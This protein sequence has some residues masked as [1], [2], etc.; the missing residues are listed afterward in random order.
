M[1]AATFYETLKKFGITFFSG[2]P[3]SLLKDF[4]AYVTR[5][6]PEQHISAANEGAAVG[7]A[8]GH[9]L[10]TGSIP[11]VYMQNSGLGNAINPL[12][13]LA[14]TDVYRIPML[15]IIGWR[16][17]PG[18]KD[19]PQHQVQ[20][21]ITL[22]ILK[23]LGI[24][25]LTISANTDENEIRAFLVENLSAESGPAAIVVSQDTFE[26][27]S[28]VS[29]GSPDLKLTRRTALESLL[30]ALSKKDIIIS[31]T[32]KLSRE[33]LAIRHAEIDPQA[34]FL[35]VGG[36]GHASSIATGVA[37]S[38]PQRRVFCLDGDGALQ[39]HLGAAA[40]IGEVLPPNLTHLLFNNG[41]HESVG[42]QP[43]TAPNL[44]YQLLAEALG[45]RKQFLA[46]DSDAISNAVLNCTTN[47]GPTFIE[48]LLKVSHDSTLPRPNKTP[49]ENKRDFQKFLK[50]V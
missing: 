11:A 21:R 25:N 30:K 48:I 42:G 39:M 36:M 38:S 41:S 12:V 10:V 45:Y 3:D 6:V 18:K 35:C 17:E 29:L 15:L 2:V 33:L 14:H 27:D 37:I 9:H 50:G 1:K 32:G 26:M 16:G 31:T 46:D 47:T 5:V 44:N 4:C 22:P 24:P 23:T 43:V 8:I 19:E 40:T 13:S 49:L 20:G 7:L 34:D 28:Q